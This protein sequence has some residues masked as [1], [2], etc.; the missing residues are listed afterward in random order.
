MS[1]DTDCVDDFKKQLA[2]TIEKEQLTL[3]QVY[4]CD[5]TGLCWKA[6]PSKTLASQRE[7]TAPGYKGCKERVTIYTDMSMQML[8]VITN[9]SAA[10]LQGN[11]RTRFRLV[12][13]V[14]WLCPPSG[15]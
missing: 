5:E 15:E 8:R 10:Q 2:D 9:Y 7:K 3:N 12:S 4:N 6:L 11:V 13:H 1:A 14:F